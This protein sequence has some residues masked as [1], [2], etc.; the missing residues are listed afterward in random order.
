MNTMTNQMLRIVMA[1][2]NRGKLAELSELTRGS[3]IEWVG[4]EEASGKRFSVVEDQLSFVGNAVKKARAASQCTG[5]WA[6]ADDSGLEVDA[7]DGAPGVRS[8][9]FASE[10]ATDQENNVK[11]MQVLK[12]IRDSERTARFRCVLALVGPG[13][14]VP[15]ISEG[16]CEGWIGREC[17][18]QCGFGYD[19]LFVVAAFPGRTMAELSLSEKNQVSHRGHALREFLQKLTKLPG[20]P[21]VIEEASQDHPSGRE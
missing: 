4:V 11:L 13:L 7:L 12:D 9:R 10:Q 19:P 5:L 2:G 15:L 14:E 17:R 6:L 20:S 8:A 18:G 21:V 3:G 16:V 1:T